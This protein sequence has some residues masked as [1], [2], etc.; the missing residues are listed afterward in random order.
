[1]SLAVGYV[2]DGWSLACPARGAPAHQTSWLHEI[3]RLAAVTV[4]PKRAASALAASA[5]GS[6]PT[7]ARASAR[8]IKVDV[9]RAMKTAGRARASSRGR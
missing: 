2:W 8:S 3:L 9:S 1:M 4:Q 6:L 5:S 7:A